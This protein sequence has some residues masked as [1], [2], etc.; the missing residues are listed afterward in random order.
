[1]LALK[2]ILGIIILIVLLL[3]IKVKVSFHSEDGVDLDIKWLFLKFRILPKKEKPKKPKKEKTKKDK[4]KKEKEKKP[5]DDKEK[6]KE[7]K[8]GDNIFVRFYKNNGVSGVVELLGRIKEVLGGMCSSIA[9]AFTIEE[10]FISLLVGAGD[11]AETA[12]KY[13]KTCAEVYP[14]MGYIVDNMR[15]KK[16]N[17]EVNPDFIN[18]RNK[19]RLHGTVSVVPQQLINAL[20]VTLFKFI[21]KVIIKFIKGSKKQKAPVNSQ[22]NNIKPSA[23]NQAQNTNKVNNPEENPEN[24]KK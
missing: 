24:I 16:Y 21:F 4:P 17:I 2:I 19:A 11:S 22:Q 20:V 14:V 9:K 5:K 10:I 6:D 1:M 8:S 13:G 23:E 12:I 15:V 3:C 18:G 7:K